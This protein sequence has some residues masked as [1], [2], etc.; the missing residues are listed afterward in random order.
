ME[1]LVFGDSGFRGVAV[2]VGDPLKG[3]GKIL[4]AGPVRR[5]VP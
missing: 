5:T 2:R 1:G 4:V 3:F